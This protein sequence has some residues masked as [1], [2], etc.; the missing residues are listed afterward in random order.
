MS[1]RAWR[2]RRNGAHS[3]EG[4]L[5]K[6][7]IKDA[8]RRLE[9]DGYDLSHCEYLRGG[10]CSAAPCAYYGEPRCVT[11][12]PEYGWPIATMRNPERLARRIL[13]AA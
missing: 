7:L 11:E 2:A 5:A 4:R 3:A 1:A 6:A 12:E 10:T 13:G 9:V 8:R